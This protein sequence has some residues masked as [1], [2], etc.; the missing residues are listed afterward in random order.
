VLATSVAQVADATSLL[1]TID[2]ASFL[3]GAGL[4]AVA[5]AATSPATIVGACA[6]MYL[7]GSAIIVGIP[8][9]ARPQAH[10]DEHP[11]RAALAGLDE[12]LRE[13]G[14]RLGGLFV[15]ALAVVE[16]LVGVL[17]IATAIELLGI[18]TAGVGYLNIARGA[19][20]VVGGLIAWR[21]LGRR[22]L[23]TT[24]TAGA[25]VLGI[26]LMLV[27]ATASPAI[28]II[29]WACVGAGCVLV[30]VSGLT[31]AQRF[32]GD[33]VLGRVLAS[34]EAS[35]VAM[36]GI[37]ALLA[38]ALVALAGTRGALAISGVVLPVLALAARVPLA[39]L[40]APTQVGEREFAL[41]RRCAVFEP[42]PL[43]VAETVAARLTEVAAASGEPI[44]VQ[45]DPGESYYIIASGRVE[46]VED[47]IVRRELGPGDGFGE[48]ALL[49]DVPRT[50][51][52]RAIEPTDLLAL[53]RDSFLLTVTGHADSHRTA[54][55]IAAEHVGAA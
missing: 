4:G 44:V 35:V 22:R 16:G 27:G 14:L 13:R 28:G 54:S 37:G 6:V 19:G 2:T 49:R 26:P 7:V 29:A 33:R 53:D 40:P 48:I 5:L 1:G 34:M 24:F 11:M 21:V 17:V 46:V 50:A 39:R 45:G 9:D 51:S 47:G 42:L 3:V 41:V 36:T 38:P 55:A 43:A 8:R 32:T 30:R 18:G 20:G 23:G 10:G 52:V 25:F 31:L 12:I 15:T